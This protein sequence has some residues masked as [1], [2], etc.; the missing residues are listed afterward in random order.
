M[1]LR[2]LM[3]DTETNCNNSDPTSIQCGEDVHSVGLSLKALSLGIIFIVSMVM[4]G[5]VCLVFYK[6][7]Q[8][9]SVSNT[10]VLNLICCQLRVLNYGSTRVHFVSKFLHTQIIKLPVYW[11]YMIINKRTA[12]YDSQEQS[13]ALLTQTVRRDLSMAIRDLIEHGLMEQITQGYKEIIDLLAKYPNCRVTFLETPFYSIINW[14]TKQHHKDPSVFSEQEHILEQQ[15]IA[16]NKEVKAINTSLHSHSPDFNYD[17]YRTSKY[18]SS[19][20]KGSTKQRKFFNI[21]LYPDGIHPDPAL[22]KAWLRKI[23][24]QIFINCWSSH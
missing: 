16:L 10:F 9:L 14:N 1:I 18:R 20:H 5:T 8:L 12:K 6:K 17:L 13:S 23:L 7:T 19:K 24:Q 3:T 4:N 21:A 2:H 15:V 22:A 11:I